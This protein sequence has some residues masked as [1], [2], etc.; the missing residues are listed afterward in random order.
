MTSTYQKNTNAQMNDWGLRVCDLDR[1]TTLAQNV[2][3]SFTVPATGEPLGA[4]TSKTNKFYQAVFHFQPVSAAVFVSNTGTAV[5]PTG[6]FAAT[7]SEMLEHGMGRRVTG[8]STLSFITG[9]AAGAIVSVSLFP[10]E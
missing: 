2:A 10:V 7:A 8:G 1:T 4:S 6:S 5:V 3:Q 9:D